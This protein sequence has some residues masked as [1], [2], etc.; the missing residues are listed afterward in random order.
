MVI[1][2]EDWGCFGSNVG[3]NDDVHVADDGD[4]EGVVGDDDCNGYGGNID[5]VSLEYD[6]D[7]YSGSGGYDDMHILHC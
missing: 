7:A 2:R 4:D 6:G 3:D 1:E 5:V